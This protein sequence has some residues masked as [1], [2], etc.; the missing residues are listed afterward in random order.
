MLKSAKHK[1]ASKKERGIWERRPG[2]WYARWR[3]RGV[4]HREYAGSR[5]RALQLYRLRT[6]EILQGKLPQALRTGKKLLFADL[7]RDASEWLQTQTR[8]SNGEMARVELL[9]KLFGNLPAESITPQ[10]IE[11]T[12]REAAMAPREPGGPSRNWSA[13]TQNR[14]KALLSLVYKLAVRNGK[15]LSNPAR[16]VPM[17]KESNHVVRYLDAEEEARLRLVVEPK[18]PERWAA[19]QLALMT[20]MRRSEQW[21]LRWAEVNR[22]TRLITL[23]ET[24]NGSLRFIPLNDAALSALDVL[25]HHTKATGFVCPRQHYRVWFEKALVDAGIKDFTWHCLRHTTASRATMMG[26]ELTAVG[27]LLGHRTLQTTL[28]YSH[29]APEHMADA[30]T[31]LGAFGSIKTVSTESVNSA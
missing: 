17:L 1:M 15:V 25:H 23:K 13:S 10:I 2:Q 27:R 20:G 16:L 9:D 11:T 14:Y 30:V 29:L 7:V 21:A 8:R 6:V 12:F 3:H 5:T 19:I 22:S 24:K 18:H 26:V 4:L 28:R 31:K